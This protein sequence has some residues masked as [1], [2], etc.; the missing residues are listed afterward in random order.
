MIGGGKFANMI[1]LKQMNTSRLQSAINGN[2]KHHNDG[3]YL[4]NSSQII[5]NKDYMTYD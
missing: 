5:S 2:R 3:R 1:S 4:R